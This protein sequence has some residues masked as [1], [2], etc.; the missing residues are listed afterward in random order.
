MRLEINEVRHMSATFLSD[1]EW[2]GGRAAKPP[3][4]NWTWERGV[5]VGHS[6]RCVIESVVQSVLEEVGVSVGVLGGIVDVV[7]DPF[8]VGDGTWIGALYRG[9]LIRVKLPV[10]TS[11]EEI[12]LPIPTPDESSIEVVRDALKTF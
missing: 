10:L 12:Y 2:L 9:P 8:P 5:T 3:K 7:R 6:K 4:S 1:S 11:L